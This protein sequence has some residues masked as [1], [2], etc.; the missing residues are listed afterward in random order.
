[1]SAGEGQMDKPNIIL[2]KT[3][4]L[5]YSELGSYGQMLIQTPNLDR[6]A[7]HGLRFTQHYSTGRCWPSRACLLT[8]YYAQQVR[9][10]R[11][12]GEAGVERVDSGRDDLHRARNAAERRATLLR[13]DAAAK[14][15]GGTPVSVQRPIP[16]EIRL[17]LPD[18][19]HGWNGMEHRFLGLEAGGESQGICAHLPSAISA[20]FWYRWSRSLASALL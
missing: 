19:V 11:L 16:S 14:G 9:R 5:G 4:D 20:Q 12:D 13:Q 10:D 15:C 3:D 17:S 7:A 1:M 2:I 18:L 6:L 8:G